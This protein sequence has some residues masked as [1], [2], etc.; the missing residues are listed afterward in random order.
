MYRGN[1]SLHTFLNIFFYSKIFEFFQIFVGFNRINCI[2]LLKEHI[3]LRCEYSY[4]VVK[5]KE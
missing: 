3:P 5:I 2:I 4:F 1:F